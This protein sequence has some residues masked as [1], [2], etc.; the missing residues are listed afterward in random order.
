MRVLAR[1]VD[2]AEEWDPDRLLVVTRAGGRLTGRVS[3]MVPDCT[4]GCHGASPLCSSHTSQLVR[5]GAVSVEAWLADGGPRPIRRRASRELCIVTA[6]GE[7]CSRPPGGRR[8]LCKT[9]AAAWKNTCRSGVSFEDFLANAR[10][11]VGFGPCEVASCFLD[12][13]F[14]Q[15]GLC[16]G[17]YHVW[18]RQGRPTGG[19]FEA[20]AARAAQPVNSGVL[21]LRGLSELVRFELLYGIGCRVAEQMDT[22]PWQLR[23]FVDGLRA[24]G[25]VSVTEFDLNSI[26]ANNNGPYARFVV[27]RVRLAYADPETAREGDVWDLRMFGRSGRL[28]FTGIR[29]DWL[30]EAVKEWAAVRLVGVRSVSA[31]Q[32][33]VHAVGLLSSVLASRP[34]GGHNPG[35]LGRADI[36][37]FLLRRESFRTRQGGRPYGPRRAVGIVED[38]ALVLRQTRE[39]GLTPDVAATFSF[40]RGDTGRRPGE[41]EVGAALPAHVITHLDGHLHLLRAVPGSSPVT[42]RRVLG[43]QAGEM[44][45]L[46]YR[47]LKST[48][49]RAGEVASLHL[50]CLD[51]DEHGRPVL[52]YDNHKAGR[53][54]RRLPISDTGL[55]E[56]IR[57]QQA[58]VA[59]RFVDTP[60][61]RLWLLPRP[62]RNT[63]GTAHIGSHEIMIWIVG[64][65]SRLPDLDVAPA[66]ALAPF[67]RSAIHPHAFR[68]TYAQTLADQG[69]PAPVLRDLMDHRSIDTT[70]GYFRVGETRK[71]EAMELLARHTIDNCGTARPIEGARSRSA[72][73]AEQLSWVAV[74]MGKCSEP[75]N[76]RAGGQ[77]CPIRYQCAACPHFESDPSYL[78]ELAAYAEDLR[79]EREAMTATGAADWL[80]EGVTRQLDIVISHIRTHQQILAGLPDDE[81]GA[82]TDAAATLSKVRQSVPVAFKRRRSGQQQ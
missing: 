31:V 74:P 5:S 4:I 80:V 66:G 38:C 60:R 10:P 72:E 50:D 81:R 36:D 22:N 16:D 24:A 61:D 64:W 62:T 57:D 42:A 32:Q 18:Y 43:E 70:M 29:Q 76:V 33:Q 56:A 26:G 40:R 27:D 6:H 65:A 30:R 8:Q 52:L 53:M 3:C 82:V 55:V 34:G 46:I 7:R 37:R 77:S 14:K 69:V 25:A 21:S 19:R 1:S 11:L 41:D 48:G 78:P 44:A 49:R 68:H 47:L 9:H 39:M 73:L 59:Q 2:L 63:D 12:A 28:D 79:R 45:V 20:W 58:W 13:V 35:T 15:A 71:R 17:H 51:V 23:G 67:D 75:T 54:G